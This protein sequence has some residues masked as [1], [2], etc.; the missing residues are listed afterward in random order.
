M[1]A[2]SIILIGLGILCVFASMCFA[3]HC[4]GYIGVM[5]E[6]KQILIIV[7]SILAILVSFGIIASGVVTY[8]YIEEIEVLHDEII[9]L[10]PEAGVEGSFV[11]GSGCIDTRM[12]YFTYV[13]TEKGYLIRK[14]STENQ[15][16]YIRE[17]DGTPRVCKIKE[18]WSL[19][20]Y[21]VIYVPEGTIISQF[22][23]Y[24]S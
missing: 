6:K 13:K 11:L 16:V 15:D 7:I 14:I 22:D 12:F 23:L 4:E 1:V 9:S 19:N 20:D 10:Q 5:T 21:I 8:A 3:V 2:L 17:T 24:Q 18:R